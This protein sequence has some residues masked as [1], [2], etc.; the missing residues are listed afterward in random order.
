MY[1]RTRAA[2]KLAIRDNW[3]DRISIGTDTNGNNLWENWT[4]PELKMRVNLDYSDL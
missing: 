4:L 2:I 1:Q 3:T